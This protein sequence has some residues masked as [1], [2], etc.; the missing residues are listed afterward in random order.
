[1][2]TGMSK[3]TQELINVLAQSSIIPM[4]L[5]TKWL[6]GVVQRSFEQ[7]KAKYEEIN[8]EWCAWAS[9]SLVAPVSQVLSELP[10]HIDPIR[11]MVWECLGDEDYGTWVWRCPVEEAAHRVSMS[12]L[13]LRDFYN[14]R[15]DQLSRVIGRIGTFQMTPET[16]S[17]HTLALSF[18]GLSHEDA[19]GVEFESIYQCA[20]GFSSLISARVHRLLG[21]SVE[22][23]VLLGGTPCGTPEYEQ[24]LQDLLKLIKEMSDEYCYKNCHKNN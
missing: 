20:E 18:S 22:V 21:N 7:V 24:Q 3:Y 23:Y 5:K 15:I 11:G 13:F 1:M 10:E 6:K 2:K 4:S 8:P 17:V 19:V 12:I 16:N 9:S 14:L